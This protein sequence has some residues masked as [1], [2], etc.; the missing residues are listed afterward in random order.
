MRVVG[1]NQLYSSVVLTLPP[2]LW[3]LVSRWAR[4]A[5]DTLSLMKFFRTRDS[6]FL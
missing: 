2:V 6:D 3:V 5:T 4:F 1:A